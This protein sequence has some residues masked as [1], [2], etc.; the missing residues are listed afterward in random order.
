MGK[1]DNYYEINK[2]FNIKNFIY[3]IILV[4]FIF[5]IYISYCNYLYTVNDQDLNKINKFNYNKN[6]K[7]CLLISGQIRDNF[8]KIF[9]YQKKF[10]ID[11]L[12]TDIFCVFSD[13]I[14]PQKKKYIENIIQPKNILWVKNKNT[15]NLY[16]LYEKIYLCNNLKINYENKNHFKYDICIRI[17]PDLYVKDFIDENLIN[18]I[19]KNVL[20]HPKIPFIS[21]NDQIF[22]CDTQ[23]MN[24]IS[25]FDI[26]KTNCNISELY[27]Y[28]KILKNKIKIK[29]LNYISIIDKYMNKNNN[30]FNISNFLIFL[31]LKFIKESY[32]YNYKMY[33]M[34]SNIK[35]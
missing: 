1:K 30:P 11:P 9:K 4:I 5:Y 27:L 10:I 7:T 22:I 13:D 19:E 8:E 34:C 21:T 3:L 31:Y 12:N 24:K 15:L 2:Y 35:I 25:K 20:Y 16:L 17:R 28:K 6:K 29:Y 32:I 23:T 18:H 14:S 33:Y 26:I